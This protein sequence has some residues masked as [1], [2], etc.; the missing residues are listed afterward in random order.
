MKFR[1]ATAAMLAWFAMAA[2]TT[3]ADEVFLPH[4]GLVL[5]GNLERADG[6]SLADG[7]ILM[8]HAG[9][10]HRGM[11]IMT[12]LQTLLGERGYSTLAINLSLGLENRHGM[13]DCR[14][15]HRHRFTDAAQEIGAWVAWL[16]SRGAGEVTL[17][18]H[19]RGGAQTAMYAAGS[20]TAPVRQVIL[21]APDT[22]E[23]NDAAAYGKRYA[24]PLAPLLER[25]QRLIDAGQGDE[26][27][28]H[29]DFL[30]C[31]D[32]S[33]TAETFV[34]YYGADPRLD[35]VNAIR[36][37][38]KPTLLLLAGDDEILVNNGKYRSLPENGSLQVQTIDGAG[39]FFL[40]LY[41]DDAADAIDAFL[42]ANARGGH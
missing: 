8:T 40:D 34:S 6:R 33:V 32:T 22:R 2:G 29:V 17:L 30:Y 9:L 1:V 15:P 11:E 21:V 18:G 38:T 10:A 5:N 14:T 7:V 25:A 27:L 16:E 20:D 28:E 4:G 35:A 19:S 41:A 24:K 39:H 36:A 26:M 31:P 42:K 12:R 13:Y 23:T 37:L 3:G